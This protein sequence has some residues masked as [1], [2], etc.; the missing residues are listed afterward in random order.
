MACA[1]SSPDTKW[2][3][4][5]S[6]NVSLIIHKEDGLVKN[7]SLIQSVF[8]NL[9]KHQVWLFRRTIK[10]FP[11][12]GICYLDYFPCYLGCKMP[13]LQLLAM[14]CDQVVDKS[15]KCSYRVN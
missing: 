12:S 7:G 13:T 1:I 6:L 10:R 15:C 5:D 8:F 9:R 4:R 3:P 2:H 14:V 11:C